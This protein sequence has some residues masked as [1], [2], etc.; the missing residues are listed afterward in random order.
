MNFFSTCKNQDDFAELKYDIDSLHIIGDG[1]LSWLRPKIQFSCNLK[2]V[3]AWPCNDKK[4]RHANEINRM[5][6]TFLPGIR[7]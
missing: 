4:V 6:S 3:H 7:F 1:T 2:S 5:F